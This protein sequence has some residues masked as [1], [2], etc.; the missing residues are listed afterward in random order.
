MM[1][2]IFHRDIT[3]IVRIGFEYCLEGQTLD[4]ILITLTLI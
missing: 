3:K 1:Q 2:N 4:E